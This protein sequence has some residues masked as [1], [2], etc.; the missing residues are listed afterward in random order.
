VKPFRSKWSA[1]RNRDADASWILLD[2]AE[3]LGW[4][5]WRRF[6][7]R[8]AGCGVVITS[9]RPGLLPTLIHCS[10]SPE[11][12]LGIVET[13]L[14]EPLTCKRRVTELFGKHHGNLR[15]ALREMY[16]IWAADEPWKP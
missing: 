3:Q 2:G 8:T 9:H 11:L 10:T 7:W 4:L 15:D 5:D 1:R 16:D 13:L 14:G 12:L 6:L